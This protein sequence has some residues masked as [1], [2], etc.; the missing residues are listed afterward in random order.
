MRHKQRY[1]YTVTHRRFVRIALIMTIALIAVIVITCALYTSV[2]LERNRGYV[3]GVMNQY[4]DSL[5]AQLEEYAQLVQTAAYDPSVRDYLLAEDA[6][7][8]HLA[9][10][11]V[12]TLFSNL[13]MVRNGIE[14]FFV[15]RP[16]DAQITYVRLGAEQPA[17]MRRLWQCKKPEIIGIFP[18]S[19]TAI[20]T[21][22]S[23]AWLT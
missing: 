16:D 13:K 20:T 15:F 18:S 17:L 9:G 23:G 14:D 7:E 10:L 4:R 6:Y 12:S 22:K 8:R 5:D 3:E 1:A 2:I 21:T 19:V 11:R